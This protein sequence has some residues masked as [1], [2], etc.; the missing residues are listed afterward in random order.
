MKKRGER[1][2]TLRKG[3]GKKEERKIVVAVVPITLFLNNRWLLEKEQRAL[4]LS[5]VDFPYHLPGGEGCKLSQVLFC[6]KDWNPPGDMHLLGYTS[7]LSRPSAPL[8]VKYLI[9]VFLEMVSYCPS[10]VSR[11]PVLCWCWCR[12]RSPSMAF[13]PRVVPDY[14]LVTTALLQNTPQPHVLPV[15]AN[16]MHG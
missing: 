8:N 9:K 7:A 6:T 14:T 10:F 16:R 11:C 3:K 12:P 15:W 4:A 1:K 5:G 2:V 13:A